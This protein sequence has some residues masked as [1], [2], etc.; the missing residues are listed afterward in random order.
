[1]ARLEIILGCMFSGKSS[2]LIRR[3]SRY[4]AIGHKCCVI[5]SA[6]D[7]RT[8]GVATHSGK[9]R[10]ALKVHELGAA[11]SSH[12]FLDAQV[13]AVDEAQFFG[14]LVDFCLLCEVL[15][16]TLI[17]AGLDG[18]ADRKPFGHIL[19]CIPLCDE[20]VKLTAMDMVSKDGTPA[21]F[22]KRL[23][24]GAAVVDVGGT[25]K[26]AAVSRKNY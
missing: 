8:D 22:S 16:K 11:T 4:E 23:S 25:D 19:Q 6:L 26:Y 15:G 9:S 5:N 17:V 24:S 13:V 14:D 20:V 10:E 2:E 21:I 1:M 7:S 3:V 12:V 18:D